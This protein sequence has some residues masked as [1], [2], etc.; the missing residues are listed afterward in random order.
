MSSRLVS[1]QQQITRYQCESDI[2]D[3]KS[4]IAGE[5]AMLVDDLEYRISS[6]SNK[7]VRCVLTSYVNSFPSVPY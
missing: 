2:C 3:G 5:S 7:P 6:T 1:G 4:E